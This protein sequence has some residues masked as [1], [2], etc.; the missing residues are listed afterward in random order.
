MN[1]IAKNGYRV[2]VCVPVKASCWPSS[3]I[4]HYLDALLADLRVFDFDQIL[5]ARPAT[6]RD[7]PWQRG[8]GETPEDWE[9]WIQSWTAQAS[10]GELRQALSSELA[11]PATASIARL[12][13]V[14]PIFPEAVSNPFDLSYFD[15]FV[16]LSEDRSIVPDWLASVFG[17]PSQRQELLSRLRADLSIAE[18]MLEST[19]LSRGE[20]LDRPRWIDKQP[21]DRDLG[22]SHDELLSR[23]Q[24]DRQDFDRVGEEP[25]LRPRR[26]ADE[27][28]ADTEVYLGVASPDQVAP[29]ELFVARFAAYSA[30]FRAE[31]RRLL[32]S[33]APTAEQRLDLEKSR[34]KIGTQVVVQLAAEGAT[35]DPPVQQFTW[36][37]RRQM[38]RFDVRVES[39]VV[40]RKLVLRFDLFVAGIRILALRPEVAVDAGGVPAEREHE[41]Q[42]PKSAF[43]S[44]AR[45][46]EREV[47]GRV[48][49]VQ[50]QTGMD[51][52][53][54]RF[55]ILPGREWEKVLAEEIANRDLFWLFWSRHAM[56][57]Q[58]VDWEWRTA[59]AKKTL[60]GI[61]P[62]PLEPADV[63]PPPDELKSIQFGAAYESYLRSL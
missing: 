26:G 29:G 34:W 20:R 32:R 24:V 46:D 37:G 8:D 19:G 18:P 47:L 27:A 43:A 48:R 62:H 58:F 57:S 12:A 15:V 25:A 39:G 52:F 4:R 59:L 1:D 36:D 16:E 44:Y 23:A 61:L 7:R 56:K 41:I 53:L 22:G 33:E 21:F 13:V 55:G 63:A 6:G 10:P 14:L 54:D 40:S 50:I 17:Y 49:S 11:E 28:V 42:A 38:L 45:E 60:S 3:R 2:L 30:P 31:I 35:V 9:R 5:V 51:V